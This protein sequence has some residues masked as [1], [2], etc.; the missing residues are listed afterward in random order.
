MKV[1]RRPAASLPNTQQRRFFKSRAAIPSSWNGA[2]RSRRQSRMAQVV[3][4]SP[5][6]ALGDRLEFANIFIP[7]SK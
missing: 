6:V 2:S 5:L 1:W 7:Q 3:G 4:Y